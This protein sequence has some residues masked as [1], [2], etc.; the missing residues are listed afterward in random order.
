[1]KKIIITGEFDGE[2]IWRYETANDRL[3]EAIQNIL[4]VY[5]EQELI[6]EAKRLTQNND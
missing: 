6:N 5:K 1:M 3:Q 4:I 2:I